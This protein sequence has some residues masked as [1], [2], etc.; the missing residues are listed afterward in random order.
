MRDN[1]LNEKQRI[2]IELDVILTMVNMRPYYMV[3]LQ[4][5]RK[6]HWKTLSYAWLENFNSCLNSYTIEETYDFM[7]EYLKTNA[8]EKETNNIKSFVKFSK[9]KTNDNN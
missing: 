3:K 1:Y 9:D 7:I 2:R 6:W 5:K 4:E 8:K